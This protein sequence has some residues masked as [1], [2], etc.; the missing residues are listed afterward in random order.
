MLQA[1]FRFTD[2]IYRSSIDVLLGDSKDD[3][4]QY[5]YKMF[6]I[7]FEIQA[8]DGVTV[9]MD[10]KEFGQ[11]IVIWLRSQARR[12]DLASTIAHEAHH[13]VMAVLQRR[14][15]KNKAIIDEA[16]AYLLGYYVEHIT[17]GIEKSLKKKK[18]AK[19]K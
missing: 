2:P 3:A 14:G 5:I 16:G 10:H 6:G 15:L 18:R 4:E 11:R 12:S 8:C 1:S 19:K 13:A 17:E 7:D 9:M